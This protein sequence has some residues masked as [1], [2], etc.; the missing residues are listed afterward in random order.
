MNTVWIIIL[1]LFIYHL[2]GIIALLIIDAKGA[3]DEDFM[4]IYI[5][6]LFGVVFLLIKAIAA[7]IRRRRKQKYGAIVRRIADERGEFEGVLC[8]H[9][10]LPYFENSNNWE[11]VKRYPL[12]EDIFEGYYVKSE[13]GEKI[14]R[15]YTLRNVTQQEIEEV[16]N[17]RN[18]FNC[19]HNGRECNYDSCLCKED[20]CGHNIDGYSKFERNANGKRK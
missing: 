19:V 10:D 14:Y 5:T 13:T 15:G 16:K 11:L 17:E 2:I 6:G 9:K 1:T 8:R 20:V 18:C 12:P 4:C 3:D 7:K